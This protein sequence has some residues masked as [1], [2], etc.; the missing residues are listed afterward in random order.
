MK[1]HIQSYNGFDITDTIRQFALNKFS[2]LTKVIHGQHAE[3]FVTLGRVT[4]HHK[5]GDVYKVSVQV[6]NGKENFQKE[7]TH[8]DLYAAIDVAK[9]SIEHTIVN[10]S[11]K[12]RSLIRRTASLFKNLLRK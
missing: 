8:H 4:H 3:C 9:D 11:Q 2:S 6:K 1:L 10:K 5:Q 12:K 7:E